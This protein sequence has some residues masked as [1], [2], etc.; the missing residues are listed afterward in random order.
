M[1]D[2]FNKNKD[3]DYDKIMSDRNIFNKTVYTPLSEAI[4]ILEKRQ[5]DN[6]LIQKIEKLLNDDIPEPLRKIDKYGVNEKQ[7]AI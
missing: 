2:N 4:K 7:V 5:T 1:N 3:W 6:S